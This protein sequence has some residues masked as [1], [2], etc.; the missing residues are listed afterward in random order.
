MRRHNFMDAWK[1]WKGLQSGD[2]CLVNLISQL[3]ALKTHEHKA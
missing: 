3:Q 1:R 2:K